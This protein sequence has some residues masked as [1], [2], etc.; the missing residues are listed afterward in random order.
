MRCLVDID[1]TIGG[2]RTIIYNI[3]NFEEY[4]LNLCSKVNE[5]VRA[6]SRRWYYIDNKQTS[7]LC[8]T[9]YCTLI[10]ML[11]SKTVSNEI[12]RTHKR[13]LRVLH[14][15]DNLLFDVR[16][17]R[18]KNPYQ[19]PSKT[20]I[21]GIQSSEIFKPIIPLGFFKNYI[22]AFD[23]EPEILPLQKTCI[24]G[25]ARIVRKILDIID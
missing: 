22:A 17:K 2:S 3:L 14:K 4:V 1:P 20:N 6:F 15:D 7:I 8:N 24:I 11:S 25:M 13:P 16:L 10:R 21:R 18:H 9:N 12:N 19:E 23:F 5:K